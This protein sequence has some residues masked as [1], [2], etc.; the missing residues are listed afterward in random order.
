[1]LREVFFFL[2]EIFFCSRS[3][4]DRK[5]SKKK[6]VHRNS[7]YFKKRCVTDLFSNRVSFKQPTDDKLLH[8]GCRY[9]TKKRLKTLN[10][11]FPNRVSFKQPTDD[12]FLNGCVDTIFLYSTCLLTNPLHY[13][14]GTIKKKTN[15]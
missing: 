8:A 12:E 4:F 15:G 14:Y 3:F 2:R 5:K 6:K 10:N 11:L 9:S 7:Q 13:C 1:M